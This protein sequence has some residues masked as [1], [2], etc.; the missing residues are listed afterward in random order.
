M[1]IQQ[2]ID[3]VSKLI[4]TE[5]HFTEVYNYMESKELFGPLIT[6][7]KRLWW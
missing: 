6:A 2:Q 1:L 4:V 3:N 5:G 7:E